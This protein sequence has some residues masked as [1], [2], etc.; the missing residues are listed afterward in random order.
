ME[1]RRTS[2]KLT[3]TAKFYLEGPAMCMDELRHMG[4]S[5]L[6]FSETGARPSLTILHVNEDILKSRRFE[7]GS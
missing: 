3:Q 7:E 4:T 5:R 6:P 2:D 1:S